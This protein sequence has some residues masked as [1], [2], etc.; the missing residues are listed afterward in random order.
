MLNKS[1]KS[2]SILKKG[3]RMFSAFGCDHNNMYTMLENGCIHKHALKV[4]QAQTS[5]NNVKYHLC[6]F[7]TCT[8][9]HN[10]VLLREARIQSKHIK[11]FSQVVSRNL[12]LCRLF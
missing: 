10:F 8:V 4:A 6:I 2:T 9:T 5:S 3:S 1:S 7:K 11:C 12:H